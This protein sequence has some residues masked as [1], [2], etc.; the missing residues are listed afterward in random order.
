MII[1]MMLS[2]IPFVIVGCV[3]AT[4]YLLRRRQERRML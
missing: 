3:V 4:V 2:L 1:A